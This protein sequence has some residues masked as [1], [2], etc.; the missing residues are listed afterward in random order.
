MDVSGKIS[1]ADDEARNKDR[2]GAQDHNK[3]IDH[4][5]KRIS[6]RC[7]Y[8]HRNTLPFNPAYPPEPNGDSCG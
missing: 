7:L 4:E 8:K 1:K 2:Y 6:R 5:F 3:P